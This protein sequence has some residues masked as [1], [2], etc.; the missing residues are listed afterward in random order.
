MR[1]IMDTVE[2]KEGGRVLELEKLNPAARGNGPGST[3]RQ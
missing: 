2:Y 3:T 1:K